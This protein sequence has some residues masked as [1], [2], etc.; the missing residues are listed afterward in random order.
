MQG[1][2][3][4]PLPCEND[5]LNLVSFNSTTYAPWLRAIVTQIARNAQ[6]LTACGRDL[7][8]QYFSNQKMGTGSGRLNTSG[9]LTAR[10]YSVSKWNKILTVHA[11]T[12]SQAVVA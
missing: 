7:V 12:N 6:H 10:I 2:N 9:Q 8:T 1:L 4:R 11:A 5:F 3:L